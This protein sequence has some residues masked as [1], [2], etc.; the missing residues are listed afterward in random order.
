MYSGK[1]AV[2]LVV[3]PRATAEP[4]RLGTARGLTEAGVRAVDELAAEIS[5]HVDRLLGGKQP[6]RVAGRV[7]S[8]QESKAKQATC[9]CGSGIPATTLH[10]GGREVMVTALPLIFAQFRD[11]GKL[12][13]DATK[14]ELMEAVKIYNPVA[15]E[16]EASWADLILR[17]YAAYCGR[18]L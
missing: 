1:P 11:A 17:E 13:D 18:S 10:W 16:D 12:P 14:G 15:A 5:H 6:G 4:V 9:S 8:Q 3:H 2:S 7:K